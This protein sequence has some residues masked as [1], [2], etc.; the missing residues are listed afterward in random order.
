MTRE[1]KLCLGMAGAFVSLLTVVVVNKLQEG[2]PPATPVVVRTETKPEVP[3]KPKPAA[4]SL[5]E[6]EVKQAVNTQPGHL[7]PLPATQEI[8]PDTLQVPAVA[9]TYGNYNTT[10]PPVPLPEN[11]SATFGAPTALAPPVPLPPDGQTTPAKTPNTHPNQLVSQA[12]ATTNL[13]GPAPT[14]NIPPVTGKDSFNTNGA[15]L[16]KPASAQSPGN[17]KN[18]PPVPSVLPTPVPPTDLKPNAPPAIPTS[19]GV[20]QKNDKSPVTEDV[21]KKQ[22]MAMGQPPVPAA[23]TPAVSTAP[24]IPAVNASDLKPIVPPVAPS[25][26]GKPGGSSGPPTPMSPDYLT[27]SKPPAV[28]RLDNLAPPPTAPLA[29]NGGAP[30]PGEPLPPVSIPNA[31]GVQTGAPALRPSPATM[32]QPP[33][34]VGAT[35]VVKDFLVQNI[36]LK[37]EDTNFAEFTRQHCISASYAQ[38]LLQYNL[39]E[40]PANSG[41]RQNPP[42]MQPGMTVK[43]PPVSV[44]EDRYP[45]LLPGLKPLTPTPAPAAA[46]PPAAVNPQLRTSS[47]SPAAEPTVSVSTLPAAPVRSSVPVVAAPAA[48]VIPAGPPVASTGGAVATAGSRQYVV[49]VQGERMRDIAERTLGDPE[50][51]SEI[52][53]LNETINPAYPIPVGTTLRLP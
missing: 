31:G 12:P 6:S 15:S 11:K 30:K 9:P 32:Q 4:K 48:P 2:E 22:V 27:N 10:A 39:E 14:F 21:L 7:P 8:K 41:L 24:V 49:Q 38:A 36:T 37:P 50:R 19:S 52:Y 13:N 44:L 35:P 42:Q 3:S 16:V 1:T 17:D 26:T 20:Q 33:V 18:L 51:W 53:R 46:P 23:P 25:N 40:N 5:P 28:Q 34:T 47:M 45:H 29:L 43:V